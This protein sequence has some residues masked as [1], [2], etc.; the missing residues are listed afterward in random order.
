MNKKD[1]YQAL[2][3]SKSASQ[4]EIKKAYHKLAQKY[5]PDKCVKCTKKKPNS[6]NL[7]CGKADRGEI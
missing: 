1:Y 7:S 6:A 2:E 4:N 5:H 3:I